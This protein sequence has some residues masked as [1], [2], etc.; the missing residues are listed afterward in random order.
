[1][2]RLDLVLSRPAANGRRSAA[3]SK[4]HRELVVNET[5]RVYPTVWVIGREGARNRSELGGYLIPAG[6]TVLMPQ[7]V[8][9][10]RRPMV[11]RSPRRHFVPSGGLT[12]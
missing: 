2:P 6:T 9:P 3:A 8:I 1:M 12:A 11:R 5:L 10:S 4:I 7:W